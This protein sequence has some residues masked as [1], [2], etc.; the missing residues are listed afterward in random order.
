MR[1]QVPEG[2]CMCVPAGTAKEQVAEVLRYYNVRVTPEDIFSRCQ[3]SAWF[4][5]RSGVAWR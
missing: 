2:M 4:A 3:V 1:S 5:S